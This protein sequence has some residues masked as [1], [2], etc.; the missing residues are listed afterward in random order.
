MT[1]AGASFNPEGEGYLQKRE[2]KWVFGEPDFLTKP[3]ADVLYAPRNH[4]HPYRPHAPF[5]HWNGGDALAGQQIAEL[6]TIDRPTWA[7]VRLDP[8]APAP[9]TR[10]TGDMFW[11]ADNHCPSFV[12][13]GSDTIWQGPM[14]DLL[15]G[16]N[17]SGVA[18]G[19]GLVGYING[20]QGQ[21]PTID[22]SRADDRT[23]SLAVVFATETEIA[24]NNSGYYTSRGFVRNVNTNGMA[25]GARLW[26]QPTGGYGTGKPS[27]GANVR[28][29]TLGHVVRS[30]ETTGSLFADITPYPF[31]DELSGVSIVS[32]TAGQVLT[33]N[34]TIWEN[35]AA[36]SA[37]KLA[38]PRSIG[39]TGD[40]T[41]SV[42]FDGSANVSGSMALASIITAGGPVGSAT[43]AP[44]FTWDSKGRLT[45]VDEVA[46]TPPWS[47][48]T[49]KPT[50]FSGLGV[51]ML[52]SDI[53]NHASRHHW[54]GADPLDGQ[55]IA[56]LR[57][58]SSPTFLDVTAGKFY[59]TSN[60]LG[61]NY[62]VGDGLW[63]GDIN[64]ANTC[65]IAGVQNP[66]IAYIKFGSAGGPT[67]GF[68]GTAFTLSSGIILNGDLSFYNGAAITY[69]G[70]G[71]G[72]RPAS[73]IVR[74]VVENT[75]V[76]AN[77]AFLATSGQFANL[78]SGF[79]KSNSSGQLINGTI[80]ATDLPGHARRHE[81][82]GA[83][84]LAGQSIAGL[85]TVD[86]P[87]FLNLFLDS[88]LRFTGYNITSYDGLGLFV[89]TSGSDQLL[90]MTVADGA[91]IGY[92]CH[93]DVQGRELG[94][95]GQ[96]WNVRSND[97]NHDLETLT[98]TNTTPGSSILSIP[99]TGNG[100]ILVNGASG[101]TR[102]YR[103][104]NAPG[105]GIM[106]RIVLFSASIDPTGFTRIYPP[107]SGQ[108]WNGGT[109]VT[110]YLE[111]SSSAG[112]LK[113]VMDSDGLNWYI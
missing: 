100:F 112:K 38:T 109:Q 42:S 41:W 27:V 85:R 89:Q 3:V 93:P 12:L 96:R 111:F 80:L 68:S 102:N 48:I 62:R 97:L 74:L 22:I 94:R 84:S 75:L 51:T 29:V 1:A 88:E 105:S 40:G 59:A 52:A 44:W 99:S 65:R 55:S 107:S 32:P 10:R 14:E 92:G 82:G 33:F 25:Q 57:T 67:L 13:E 36:G 104:P 49:S 72:L 23:K 110:T 101:S 61:Q 16:Q 43:K 70:S 77:A 47:S 34:G 64:L 81:Y 69:P 83:D 4:T 2:G 28:N 50:M 39:M 6:R 98:A 91:I 95:A 5:H 18:H 103:V 63:I 73:G 9:P 76:T 90:K 60:G 35:A 7:A 71:I 53:P 54:D 19:N 113:I 79:V 8:D 56:G 15:Y 87:G 24:Q 20:S 37:A 58:T 21:R 78:V 106:K 46:I 31:I 26:L 17:N 108:L 45:A 30:H 66:A 86:S 11:D